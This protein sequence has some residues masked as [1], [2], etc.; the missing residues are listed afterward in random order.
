MDPLWHP[1]GARAAPPKEDRSH[2]WT[3]SGCGRL[4]SGSFLLTGVPCVPQMRSL[5]FF[6]S[7]QEITSGPESGKPKPPPAAHTEAA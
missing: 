6:L 7:E 5:T 4:R 1:W 2:K 3:P